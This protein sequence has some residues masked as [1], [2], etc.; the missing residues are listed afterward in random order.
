MLS[1]FT[2]FSLQAR[3]KVVSFEGELDGDGCQYEEL[4]SVNKANIRHQKRP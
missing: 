4:K 3:C 1:M 2:V